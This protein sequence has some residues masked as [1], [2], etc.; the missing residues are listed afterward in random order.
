MKALII[1]DL[2]V[3]PSRVAGTTPKSAGELRST[4]QAQIAELVMQH[5]DK[6]LV[7]NGDALDSFDIDTRELLQFFH[8][9]CKW[10]DQSKPGVKLFNLSGNHDRSAR[11]EKCSS[12]EFLCH[13]LKA[14]AP[15]KVETRVHGEFTNLWG[16]VWSIPHCD[17]I[18]LFDLELEKALETLESGATLFLHCNYANPWEQKDHSLNITEEDAQ[19]FVDKGVRLVIAHEHQRRILKNGMVYIT[20]NQFATSISDCLG[21][22]AKY[23]HILE[24]DGTLTPIQ[25]MDVT[26]EFVRVDWRELAAVGDQPFVRVEGHAE[27]SEAGE[28]VSLI[29]K[30]RSK[31]D[32]LIISNAV[33][34][35]GVNSIADFDGI[36]L[37]DIRKFDV[38]EALLEMFTPQ[39]RK[40]LEEVLSD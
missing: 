13:I 30:Y 35:E 11:G 25:T 38:R 10:L 14:Y 37:E 34:I 39:E 29:A 36:S 23:A 7:I 28:V 19:R 20:G 1:N 18:D 8:T 24:E 12:F 33:R 2:H 4:L 40:V 5:T 9:L 3:S 6:H 26:K 27:Q 15:D 16:N 31:S 17:N 32:A 22:D 21:N